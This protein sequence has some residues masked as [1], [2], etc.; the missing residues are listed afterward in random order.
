[1]SHLHGCTARQIAGGQLLLGWVGEQ[2]GARL[3]VP[4]RPLGAFCLPAASAVEPFAERHGGVE[5][6]QP[7]HGGVEV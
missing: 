5:G 3:V 2:L 4:A 1:M 6:A 7:R